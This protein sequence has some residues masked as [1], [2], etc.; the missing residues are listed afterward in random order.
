MNWPALIVFI[1][2]FRLRHGPGLL[3][4]AVACRR[5]DPTA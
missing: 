5:P 2:L 1:A 3:G 4:R